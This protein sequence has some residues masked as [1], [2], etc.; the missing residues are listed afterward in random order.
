MDI[1][2]G[3]S[4]R[5]ADN[6]SRGVRVSDIASQGS[7]RKGLFADNAAVKN[8]VPPQ[9]YLHDPDGNRFLVVQTARCGGL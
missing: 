8:P 1:I 7:E 4:H 5:E 2:A 3:A 9:F 6:K